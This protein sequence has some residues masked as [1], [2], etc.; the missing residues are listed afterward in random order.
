MLRSV[1]GKDCPLLSKG[2]V[3]CFDA[4]DPSPFLKKIPGVAHAVAHGN[5]EYTSLEGVNENPDMRTF[6]V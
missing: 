4:A 6:I 2:T 1:R 5:V 3:G